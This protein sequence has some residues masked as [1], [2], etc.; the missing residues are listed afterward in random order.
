[1]QA[2]ARLKSLLLPK[3]GFRSDRVAVALAL[4]TTV[5]LGS[6]FVVS[7]GTQF[8][9]PGPLTSTHGAIKECGACHTKAGTSKVS[10][11][12]GLVAGDP[13]ADSNACLSCHKM[14]DTA[15]NA[16]GAAKDVLKNSTERLTKIAAASAVPLSIRTQS[17]AF[18]TSGVIARGLPCATC[19]QEHQGAKFNLKTISN[20]QCQSCHTVQF[21]SFDSN[22]PKFDSYPFKRR[23][24]VIY[25][26][27]GHFDKHYPELAAKGQAKAIPP[28]CATCHTSKADKRIMA[29]APFEQ[30][31]AACHLDQITGK[32][33]VSGPK[34]IAF[35]AL[36]GLDLASLKKKS[37]LIGEWPDSSEAPLTP[38]MKMM[39]GRTERGRAL[40]AAADT[41][42]LQDLSGAS[43]NQI[44]VVTNLVWEIKALL[45]VL[46][47]EKASDALGDLNPDGGA[48]LSA[49]LVT[50]LTASIPRDVILKA[51]Q[52][53]LP[54]LAAEIA[55]GPNATAQKASSAATTTEGVA[56]EPAPV[57]PPSLPKEPSSPDAEVSTAA[58]ESAP[59]SGKAAVP[60]K[61]DP[62]A[63]VVS[64]LGQCL[65][66]ASGEAGTGAPEAAAGNTSGNIDAGN[67]Q[68]EGAASPSK[69]PDA[70][71]NTPAGKDTF[72]RIDSRVNLL[73]GT[74]DASAN[75]SDDLLFP[76]EEERRELQA[77]GKDGGPARVDSVLSGDAVAPANAGAQ[78]QTSSAPSTDIDSNLDPEAWADYGGWYSQDYQI[79]YRPVGHK[80][81]FIYAWLVLT[82]PQAPRGGKSPAA[83]IFETLTVK[84]APGTCTKCHSVDETGPQGRRVNFSP[85]SV[86]SKQGR[87]TAFVH[88]P[89]FSTM[90][91]SGC[92]TCHELKPSPQ[93]LGSYEQGNARK[94]QSN[95]SEV[96]KELCQ[97]CHTKG[98]ARQDCVLCHQYHVNGI[99][100]P[101]TETRNPTK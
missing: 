84:D 29:V 60:V 45:H 95:F 22:H 4:V 3:S 88:E 71:T 47:S 27:A 81:K 35:L 62:P 87:F 72:Q 86:E 91:E 50:D 26:H 97:S 73:A 7:N 13:R 101:I 12:H 17:I 20:E 64:V 40:I 39:I 11:V 74:I 78:P 65:V 44:E 46:I 58:D 32:E 80:D 2:P 34:G 37:A 23:T 55:S 14:P 79:F 41:L 1:M 19:H 90:D 77:R 92:L 49:T 51:Q 85:A 52:Q 93:Y 5:C 48:K 57:E 66:S 36:P 82:G 54:N 67:S 38:F 28:T 70:G 61:R 24:P 98:M 9:M 6:V 96:K 10:W 21:D 18:P 99:A 69:P 94:F 16:H 15:F 59:E 75:Q 68:A 76:T 63:C 83:G 56:T 43:D 100:T 8:L 25:D 33:R 42:N 30:T 53:W 31:C 89:H